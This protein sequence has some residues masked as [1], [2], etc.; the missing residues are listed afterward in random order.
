MGDPLIQAWNDASHKDDW[1]VDVVYVQTFVRLVASELDRQADELSKIRKRM[2]NG[3]ARTPR[4]QA[5]SKAIRQLRARAK[6]LRGSA[7]T[8]E[9]R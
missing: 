8:E 4:Y 7:S 6:F 2:L 3:D 1:N 9:T 5:M